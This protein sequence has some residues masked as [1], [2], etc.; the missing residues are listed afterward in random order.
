QHGIGVTKGCSSP[1]NI[2]QPYSCT[3][4][5]INTV[6][7]AQDTLTFD[8]VS[9]TVHASGGNVASGNIFA[10]LRYVIGPFLMGFSTPPF[11]TAGIATG[12]AL[13]PFRS[14]PG[15]PLVSCTLPFGSRLN[16]LSNSFYTV[17]PLDFNQ[18]GHV[19]TDSVEITWHDLCNDPAH[20]GNTNCV[21][22]P[23]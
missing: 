5:V 22:N 6:D 3:Y 20:T 7:E 16:T 21:S 17:Q 14:A 23:P 10:S 2:G 11:C 19:V 13:D 18:P 15:N 4:S 8:G 1:T 9:D 12:T